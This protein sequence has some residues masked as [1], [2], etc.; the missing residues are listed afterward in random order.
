MEKKPEFK[1]RW[2]GSPDERDVLMGNVGMAYR[3]GFAVQSISGQERSERQ[4]AM[5]RIMARKGV[6]PSSSKPQPFKARK[7]KRLKSRVENTVVISHMACKRCG[8][9]GSA[10]AVAQASRSSSATSRPSDYA[11]LDSPLVNI[12]TGRPVPLNKPMVD[13]KPPGGWVFPAHGEGGSD[14]PSEE[15]LPEIQWPRLGTSRSSTE[16]SLTSGAS[17]LQRICNG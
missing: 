10:S 5:R 14:G 17:G 9:N 3:G 6:S 13:K 1:A 2:R 16:R 11:R 7:G 12:R 8:R 15:P 4:E